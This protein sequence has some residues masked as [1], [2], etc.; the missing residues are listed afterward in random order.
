MRP[1]LPLRCTL[2]LAAGLFAGQAAQAQTPAQVVDPQQRLQWRIQAV[3]HELGEGTA[4]DMAVAL[5]LYCQA[6]LAGDALSARNLGLI[7]AEGR[8]GV[9]RNDGLAAHWFARA[10]LLGDA[11]A[12]ARYK[13]IT[14]P[15]EKPACVREAEQRAASASTEQE[16]QAELARQAG[17]QRLDEQRRTLAQAYREHVDTPEERRIMNIVYRLAPRYGLDPGLVYAVIR[18][19]SNFDVNAVSDKNAQGLMQLIPE[20]AARF[21]VKKPFDAEQNIRGGMGYLRW[22]L[23]YFRGQVPL[24]VA[25]YNAGEGAVDKHG[26]IPPYAE[27][28]EYVRRIQRFYALTEHPFD[29]SLTA[30]SPL[31]QSPSAAR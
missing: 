7:H 22:L 9:P 19:E 6:A 21:A 12:E 30:P 23:S 5:R 29:A 31:L 16:R 27:T 14:V 28:R 4:P 13:Q 8:G 11:Q 15:A 2:L 20:T 17:Q 25:A 1:L 24:A 26:G 18:A 3:A 10:A